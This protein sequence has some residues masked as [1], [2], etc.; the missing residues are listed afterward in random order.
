MKVLFAVNNE[1]I[2]ETIIKKYQ[3]M[4]DELLE[5]K[6]VYYYNAIVKEI[7]KE[8]DYDIIVISEDLETISTIDKTKSDA[9]ILDKL[10]KIA[11]VF[12]VEEIKPIPILFISNEKRLIKDE[13]IPTMFNLG[14][15]D[16]LIGKDRTITKICELIKTPRTEEQARTYYNLG[17]AK[18]PGLEKEVV[19]PREIN[20]ILRHYKKILGTPDRFSSSFD[21]VAAQYDDIQLKYIIDKLPNNVKQVLEQ[22]NAKYQQ[23]LNFKKE[24]IEIIPEEIPEIKQEIQETSN[25]VIPTEINKT[26]I[27][28]QTKV[29]P[30]I[31]PIVESEIEE[32]IDEEVEEE[33]EIVLPDVEIEEEKDQLD[34][35]EEINI[36]PETIDEK[37]E[38][39]KLEEVEIQIEDSKKDSKKEVKEEIKIES[40][41]KLSDE[42]TEIVIEGA[43]DDLDIFGDSLD[44]DE[45]IPIFG[46]EELEETINEIKEKDNDI[47]I[48][49]DKFN[50]EKEE[51][52]LEI[53]DLS[54]DD[55]DI[56][57]DELSVTFDNDLNLDSEVID[58]VIDES[59]NDSLENEKVISS[60]PEVITPKIN[61]FEEK[62]KTDLVTQNKKDF[63][64][65][66]LSAVLSKDKKVVIFVGTSKNGTSFLVNSLGMM[67]AS[68][69]INTAILDM[70]KNRNSYYLSTKN[71][72]RLRQIA[73]ESTRKL[74]EGVAMGVDVVRGLTVYTALPGDQ[75]I[76]TDVESILSTLIKNYSLVL[77][78]ADFNTNFGY[79]SA[80]QEIYLVQSLDVLTI[81]PLTAF[82]KELL[83]AGVLTTE[84]VKVVLNKEV[85]VRGL[86]RK[87]LVGGISTYND[88]AMS[89]MT[90]LF[91]RNQVQ[92]ASIPF[93]QNVYSKYLENIVECKYDISG[94]PKKFVEALKVLA[95]MVYPLISKQ[96]DS[97][98]GSGA[99]TQTPQMGGSPFTNDMS[100]TLDQMRRRL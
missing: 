99:P 100:S 39:E 53:S 35:I 16:A 33:I 20:N 58:V 83:D 47:K 89:I 5:Y 13:I 1:S 72:E 69:G 59:K 10:E 78:D 46:N 75:E 41:D 86:T 17:T 62:E 80:A 76:F 15:Y 11:D 22:Q 66:D 61:I 45:F 12:K 71:D 50:K 26:N 38:I 54:K 93:D 95:N 73:I 4:Y 67:F 56:F 25:I 30:V 14:I 98:F 32:I 21:R 49:D 43:D 37:E 23:M 90:N 92:V 36:F 70:T 44:D 31:E 64:V 77:I 85:P 18:N 27:K 3:K 63:V 6:N 7:Q 51:T 34:E 87:L 68:I 55:I 48:V 65:P 88:P 79:F 81:Q 52:A 82:L 96:R 91:D 94:Y 42:F 40:E 8:K 74:R 28:S 97:G 24:D 84:K 57:D 19:N 2:S 9:F 60:Q 29:E